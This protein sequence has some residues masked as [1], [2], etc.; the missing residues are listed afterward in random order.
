MSIFL[1]G[2]SGRVLS[3]LLCDNAPRCWAPTVGSR[4]TGRAVL[5]QSHDARVRVVLSAPAAARAAKV[6]SV[7]RRPARVAH[8]HAR[9][10]Q[11]SRPPRIR[12]TTRLSRL[13]HLQVRLPFGTLPRTR[14]P[15]PPSASPLHPPTGRQQWRPAT[16]ARA[17]PT[18]RW[19]PPT[20]SS[21]GA[22]VSRP[23]RARR[24]APPRDAA[25]RPVPAAPVPAAVQQSLIAGGGR[26]TP[27]WSRRMV[28]A[29]PRLAS[30]C[31]VF[32][33]PA[34]APERGQR[35]RVPR[36]GS[37][38]RCLPT[39]SAQTGHLSGRV[40]PLTKAGAPGQAVNAAVHEAVSLCTGHSTR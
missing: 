17:A 38:T 28:R 4:A 22:G 30:T 14:P 7:H 1:W 35:K 6:S 36:S 37:E 27:V 23:A 33:P 21:R 25:G 26:D 16:S 12:V 19:G 20:G 2:I 40:G 15:L 9:V 5:A 34:S 11:G 10:G 13:T 29:A 8:T 18:D 39:F 3:S 31:S 32:P 24:R